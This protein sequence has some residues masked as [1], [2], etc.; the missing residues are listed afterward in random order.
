METNECY[1]SALKFRGSLCAEILI[2][3]DKSLLLILHVAARP[4]TENRV[5]HFI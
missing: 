4:I 1:M 3:D 2:T 5:K